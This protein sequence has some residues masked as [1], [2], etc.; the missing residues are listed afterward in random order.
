VSRP[1]AIFLLMLREM[2]KA[3][4]PIY[5]SRIAGRSRDDNGYPKPEY[6]MSFT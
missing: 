6:P 1:V 3:R 2:V 4:L 5:M